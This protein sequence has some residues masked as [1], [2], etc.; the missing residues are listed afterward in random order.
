MQWQNFNEFQFFSI[1]CAICKLHKKGF[2]QFSRD[3]KLL[4]PQTSSL[5]NA[6]LL[7]LLP[8]LL[9]H[10][11]TLHHHNQGRKVSLEQCFPFSR[12]ILS[13]RTYI[14]IE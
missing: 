11:F 2:P 8:P 3:I 14:Y 13:Y 5:C 9:L 1:C 7:L 10:G 4:K 6:L 12:V